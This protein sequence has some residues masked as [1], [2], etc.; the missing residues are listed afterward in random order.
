MSLKLIES[1]SGIDLLEAPKA[2]GR[3]VA[4][5]Y[6]VFGDESYD[7][8]KQRVYAVAGIIGSELDWEPVIQDWTARTGG[9][10]FHAKDCDTD[11]GDFAKFEHAQNKKL[12]KDLTAILAD[13][14][15]MG[16]GCAISLEDHDILFAP[17]MR[18]NGYYLCFRTVVLYMVQ[19]GRTMIPRPTEIKFTFDHNEPI[20]VNA[21][22]IYDFVVNMPGTDFG[23]YM[24]NEISFAVRRNPRIQMADLVARETMKHFDNTFGPVKRIPRGSFLALQQ[25]KRFAFEWYNKEYFHEMKRQAAEIAKAQG[26]STIFQEYDEWRAAHKNPN[27]TLEVRIRYVMSRLKNKPEE[28]PFR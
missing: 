23:D 27:D 24:S 19:I 16:Y 11:R 2:R 17:M 15:L 20:E 21:A 9:L 7:E 8:D 14:R 12:Y 25:T 5:L 6:N 3:L 26:H 22:K 10:I 4:V 18:N 28:N 1:I 13:S